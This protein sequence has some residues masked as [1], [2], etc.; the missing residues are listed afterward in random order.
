MPFLSYGFPKNTYSEIHT[1]PYGVNDIFPVFST[2]IV[3]FK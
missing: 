1:L 3:Q 2:F